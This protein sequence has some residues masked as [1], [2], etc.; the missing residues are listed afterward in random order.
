MGTTMSQELRIKVCGLTRQEDVDCACELGVDFCGFIFHPKS[1]RYV[2]PEHAAKLHSGAMRRVGVFVGQDADEINAIMATARLDFAQLHGPHS[3]ATAMKVGPERVI[4]VLWPQTYCHR[5]Q[6][7]HDLQLHAPSCSMFLFDAGQQGGGSGKI[8]DWESVAGLAIPRPWLLAGGL[9]P[10]NIVSAVRL[11]RPNGVDLNSGIET[12]PGKK[13][14]SSMRETV[15]SVRE[16][17]SEI[18]NRKVRN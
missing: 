6:L 13:N 2:T 7:S 18:L 3:V 10:H 17:S 14:A 11:M 16:N 4:R 9:G 12:E 8:F 1:A 15:N 5:A